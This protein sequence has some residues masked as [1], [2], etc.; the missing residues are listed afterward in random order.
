MRPKEFNLKYPLDLQAK[1]TKIATEN[2]AGNKVE[3]KKLVGELTPGEKALFPAFLQDSKKRR[4]TLE[5]EIE[6]G[7]E[8]KKVVIQQTAARVLPAFSSYRIAPVVPAAPS[9]PS[10]GMAGGTRRLV[11]GSSGAQ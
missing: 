6:A 3:A 7:K 10:A 11:M 4:A 8:A 1:F 2:N 5:Q 9:A